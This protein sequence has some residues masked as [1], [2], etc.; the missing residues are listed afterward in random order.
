MDFEFSK[1]AEE[2]ILLRDIKQNDVLSTIN[3]PDQIVKDENEDIRVYQSLI[4]E[5]SQ[6]FLLRVFVNIYKSPKL[7]ITVYKTTKISKYYEN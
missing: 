3:N 7:I 5:N 2:Q 4:N 6:I 1:H